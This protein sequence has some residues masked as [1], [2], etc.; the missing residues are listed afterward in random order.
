MDGAYGPG[1]VPDFKLKSR[2]RIPFQA[3]LQIQSRTG[4]GSDH[5]DKKYGSDRRKIAQMR[6]RIRLNET[7]NFVFV[8][9][10]ASMIVK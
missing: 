3:G 5:R 1:P 8:Y 4:S 6:V 9:I 2:I 10:K 7:L